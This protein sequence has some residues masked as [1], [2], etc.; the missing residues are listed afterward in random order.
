[1][2]FENITEVLDIL[3]A[4]VIK[5]ELKFRYLQ[6]NLHNGIRQIGVSVV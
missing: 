4:S 5:C 1:M 2:V 3:T 6:T